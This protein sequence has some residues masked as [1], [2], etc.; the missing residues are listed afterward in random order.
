MALNINLV[1][2]LSTLEQWGLYDVLLPFLLVFIL[3]FA[4]L[5]R[6]QL[7]GAQTR[8][9]SAIIALVVGLLLVRGG[10]QAALV[11]L[12]NAYLPNVSAVIVVFLGFLILLGLFGFGSSN[13]RG[14]IMI[15]FV[16]LAVG[17]GIWALTSATEQS[18]FEIPLLG[19]EITESDAGALIVIGIFVMIVA[20]TIMKPKERGLAGFMKGMGSIGD[21]F[22]GIPPR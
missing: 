2:I 19:V 20:I 10:E 22:A 8:K 3:V 9:F 11:Q 4:I 21:S 13:M 18:D 5:E 17:G 16:V 14:G 15:L 12:I 1:D 6:I 7:F